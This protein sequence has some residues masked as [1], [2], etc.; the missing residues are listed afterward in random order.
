MAKRTIAGADVRGKRVLVR[1][2]FNVPVK[3]GKVADATR[4][5]ASVPTI[6]HLCDQGGRVIL[7]SHLGRPDGKPDPKYSLAPVVPVL[8]ELLGRDVGFASDCVG[9][10]AE[11][12]I[13]MLKDGEVALLQ[14]VRFHKGE[15]ENDS[16]FARQLAALA[17]VYVNDAFGTAH[18]A[19]ASTEGV[20]RLLKPALAG[21]LMEKEIRY[22]G[23]QLAKPERPMTVILGGAKVSDKI[24]LIE[25]LLSK[26]DSLIIGGGMAYTFLAAQGRPIGASKLEKD[27]I[28]TAKKLLAGAAAR[29]VRILLPTD[30]VV[31]EKFDEKSP[32][33]IVTAIPEGWMAL[34]IGPETVNAFTKELSAAKTVVWNGP[35]G[36]FEMAPF[37]AG[38]KAVA[39]HLA[40]LKAVTIVGGGDTAAAVERFKVA[41]RMTHVSTGGGASLEFL[42]GRTLPGVA[43]LDD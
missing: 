3:D 6:R 13:D 15:E 40:G 42:E 28:D 27:R 10:V 4:I 39:E 16:A 32:S 21:F 36:V 26:V 19:H 24:L 18:R 25:N 17:Q 9:P 29:H 35:V 8:K 7:V 38:T 20:A 34:D 31:A 1:V 43:A 14:N 5:R 2:D 33:R 37:A 12:L 11:A 41:D 30:H 23:D 22:L